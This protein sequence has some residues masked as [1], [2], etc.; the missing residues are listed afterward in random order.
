MDFLKFLS[1]TLLMI[2]VQ[3]PSLKSALFSFQFTCHPHSLFDV[4]NELDKL[5]YTITYSSADYVPLRYAEITE[6]QQKL[7]DKAV[8]IIEN[9]DNVLGVYTNI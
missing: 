6:D 5:N 3:T 7:L 1:F 8:E 2:I 9:E 4:R